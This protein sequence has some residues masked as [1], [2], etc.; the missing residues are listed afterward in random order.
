VLHKSARAVQ[1]IVVDVIVQ[2]ADAV[3]GIGEPRAA[4]AFEQV[5]DL[6]AV[7]EGIEQRGPAAEVVKECAPPNEVARDPVQFGSDDPDVLGPGR[8]L[9]L[10]ATFHRTHKRVSVG[11]RGEIIDAA[12]VG[13]ELSVRP[14][15]PHLFLHPVD[16][17]ANR[18]RTQD[19]LAIHHHLQAQYAVSGRMLRP[20]IQHK[21]LLRDAVGSD[22]FDVGYEHEVKSFLSGW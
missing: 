15:L 11:H 3:V 8:D 6:L 5:E 16:V 2:S 17:A 12:G 18:F 22:F 9:Q 14:V 20:H 4:N 19:V 7:V 10:Q 21:R 1:E 13:Q